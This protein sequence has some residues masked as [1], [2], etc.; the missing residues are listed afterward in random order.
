MA[1][2]SF[3]DPA[4]AALM[5]DLFINIKVDREERPDLDAIYQKALSLMGQH[6]GWPLTMFLTPDGE[7]F[8]GGTYF[9]PQS[10]WGRAGF[11]D[12]LKAV[13]DAWTNRREKLLEES[14]PLL[15][16]L[17]QDPRRK[18][19]EPVSLNDLDFFATRMV[20]G[21]DRLNGGLEGAP[22]FP[23]CGYFDRLWRAGL[24]S[25]NQDL[26][27]A[28]T[29][30]LDRMFRGGIYDHLGG[31][32][33]RYSTD[34]FWLV[35]HF[36]KMLYDNA[37]ALDLLTLV[38]QTDRN[39]VHAQKIE[40]IIGWVLRE[41]LAEHGAFAA[42]LDA[43]DPGGEGHFYT[44]TK[45]EID[46]LLD[47]ESAALFAKAYDVTKTGNWEGR[48]ILQRLIGSLPFA[49]EQQLKDAR[50][51]LF[52]VRETRP[53]P[54]RDHKVL[55]DWNGMM[56]AALAQAAFVFDRS[57]WLAAARQSVGPFLLRWP[58]LGNRGIGRSGPYGPRCP[59]FVRSKWRA[60]VFGRCFGMGRFSA[61]PSFGR[62]K[63][64][65][66]PESPRCR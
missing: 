59:V 49:Q 40:E 9:P 33:M 7:P 52:K 20:N 53:R 19:H 58:G 14:K 39:P 63:W 48:T 16:K 45:T 10:R 55:A 41:M 27:D 5:N 3:E 31:G 4:I 11:P 24:K 43:D 36:E 30:T 61:H 65:I 26:K 44:W 38:W 15:A 62:T 37:Q 34:E 56:I 18:S 29:L 25:G 46:T 66:F 23:H 51:L 13:D 32:L 21:V 12:V 47:S 54:G 60:N 6:G 1:H 28:V 64:R 57:D 17:R 2:E 35:P 8:F 42:T 50:T 22:K